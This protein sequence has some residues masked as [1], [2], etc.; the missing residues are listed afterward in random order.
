[1]V[2]YHMIYKPVFS[3][4]GKLQGYDVAVRLNYLASKWEGFEVITVDKVGGLIEHSRL[5]DMLSNSYDTEKELAFIDKHPMEL[6]MYIRG[7]KPV[8]K[9]NDDWK[10]Q[11]DSWAVN[12]R[13]E[14]V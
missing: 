11:V 2:K 12:L 5:S 9:S 8:R 1:M 3:R 6:L 7:E 10:E 4:G 14:K 13:G